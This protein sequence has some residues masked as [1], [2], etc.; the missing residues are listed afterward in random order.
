M[1]DSS[2]EKGNIQHRLKNLVVSASKEMLKQP[3]RKKKRTEKKRKQNKQ[4]KKPNKYA[5]RAKEPT[6]RAPSGQTCNNLSKNK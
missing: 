6:E 5:K 4:T 2:T 1:I 3:K